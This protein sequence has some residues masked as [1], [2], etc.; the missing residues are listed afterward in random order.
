MRFL[1]TS[2][3]QNGT[4]RPSRSYSSFAAPTFSRKTVLPAFVVSTRA[5]PST[6]GGTMKPGATLISTQPVSSWQAAS[7]S[8][9]PGAKT[10]ARRSRIIALRS[11]PRLR[12]RNRVDEVVE[13][14]GGF[15]DLLGQIAHH[16]ERLLALADL[17]QLG[18]IVVVGLQRAQHLGEAPPRGVELAGR[19]F[20][21]ARDA[22]PLLEQ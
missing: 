8:R 7:A 14:V 22:V 2:N 16:L 11:R 9:T 1:R 21:L 10:I 5:A 3:S 17:H 6:S 12:R 13:H 19:R 20:G 4:R 15:V 18:D